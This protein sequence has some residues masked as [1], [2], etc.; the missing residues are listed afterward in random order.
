MQDSGALSSW[1]SEA[2][3]CANVTSERNW[4][5][6]GLH[7]TNLRV[8]DLEAQELENLPEWREKLRMALEEVGGGEASVR[9]IQVALG[10]VNYKQQNNEDELKLIF[11]KFSMFQEGVLQKILTATERV[12]NMEASTLAGFTEQ[13]YSQLEASA[14]HIS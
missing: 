8:T 2:Y 7:T 11:E 9:D 12:D 13:G 4:A 1:S 10:D 5:D 6:K 14:E 3:A